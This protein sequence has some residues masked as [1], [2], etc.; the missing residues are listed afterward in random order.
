MMALKRAENTLPRRVNLKSR[1]D[2]IR[3]NLLSDSCRAERLVVPMR[4]MSMR[5]AIVTKGSEELILVSNESE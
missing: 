3:P 2:E 1:P 4:F 5:S